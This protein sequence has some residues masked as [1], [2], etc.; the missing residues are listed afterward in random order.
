MGPTISNKT[1][2][3]LRRRDWF[4]K[5]ATDADLGRLDR[6]EGITMALKWCESCQQ[7]EPKTMLARDDE[8]TKTSELVCAECGE[9]VTNVPEHDDGDMER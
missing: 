3:K 2:R 7:L 5:I 4:L 9:P 8:E 1:I 6:R